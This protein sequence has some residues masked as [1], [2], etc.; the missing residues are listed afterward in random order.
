MKKKQRKVK[1]KMGDRQHKYVWYDGSSKQRGGRQASI[2]QRLLGSN[3]LTRIYS[4]KRK[5]TLITIGYSFADNTFTQQCILK[6]KNV[7]IGQLT[8]YR[9][10]S[11]WVFV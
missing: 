5:N 10:I 11:L 2:S 6:K 3:V 1:T 7:I 4:E 9:Y 8:H